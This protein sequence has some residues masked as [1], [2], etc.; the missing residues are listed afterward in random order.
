MSYQPPQSAPA[1]LRA[2]R[3]CECHI[4]N[5]CTLD[6]SLTTTLLVRMR[7]Y[8]CAHAYVTH[9]HARTHTQSH[10]QPRPLLQQRSTGAPGRATP[11]QQSASSHGF[12]RGHRRKVRR[13]GES[14]LLLPGLKRSKYSVHMVLPCM[15]HRLPSILASTHTA[16]STW[17]AC[18]IAHSHAVIHARTHTRT[19]TNAYTHIQPVGRRACNC[20]ALTQYGIIQLR[21]K[22]CCACVASLVQPFLGS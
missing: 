9:T 3:C 22:L 12:T 8:A 1:P 14:L 17:L 6:T 2:N 16:C 21:N 4:L 18:L 15:T 20:E 7:T 11:P 10:T 19:H 5:I 13:L